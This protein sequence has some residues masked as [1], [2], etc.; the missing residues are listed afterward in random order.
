[1]VIYDAYI[2]LHCKF[3]HVADNSNRLIGSPLCED[4]KLSTIPGYIEVL[5]PHVDIACTSEE[6]EMIEAYMQSGFYL[7]SGVD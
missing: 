6:T 4:V 2:T 1:M 7:D 5:S 3:Y